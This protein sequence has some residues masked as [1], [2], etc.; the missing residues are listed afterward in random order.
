MRSQY[1]GQPQYPKGSSTRIDKP[2]YLVKCQPLH[3][4]DLDFFGL[5]H[6]VMVHLQR[7]PVSEGVPF[8]YFILRSKRIFLCSTTSKEE[9]E[10]RGLGFL[11]IVVPVLQAPV[12]FAAGILL[13]RLLLRQMAFTVRDDATHVRYI[14]LSIHQ[15]RVHSLFSSSVRVTF[16]IPLWIPSRILLQYLDDLSPTAKILVHGFGWLV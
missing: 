5:R 7:S 13:R 8:I 16:I 10:E 1:V 3:A 4:T 2:S 15:R 6:F 12:G 11:R 9:G 14:L